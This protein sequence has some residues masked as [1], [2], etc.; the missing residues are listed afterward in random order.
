MWYILI[1]GSICLMLLAY[2][3]KRVAVRFPDTLKSPLDIFLANDGTVILAGTLILALVI[4]LLRSLSPGAVKY[5]ETRRLQEVLAHRQMAKY[6][7]L[8][9]LPACPATP[10]ALVLARA[11]SSDDPILQ[12]QL[13]GLREGFG[14][15]VEII[16]T[17]ILVPENREDQQELAMTQELQLTNRQIDDLLRKNPTCNVLVS[18][19]GVPGNFIESAAAASVRARSKAVAVYSDNVYLLGPALAEGGGNRASINALAMPRHLLNYDDSLDEPL[20]DDLEQAFNQ[21]FIYVDK[22]NLLEIAQQH[23]RIFLRNKAL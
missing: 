15:Q 3:K 11:A 4:L 19:A 22:G 9:L 2:R 1:F 12:A 5:K 7:A 14:D 21:R 18:L 20:S 13:E 8:R 6:L 17:Q 10:K 16:A 23:K